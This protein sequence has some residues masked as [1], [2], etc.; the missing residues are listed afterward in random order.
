MPGKCGV[1]ILGNSGV[2]K[3]FLAN[4]LLDQDRFPHKFSPESV[5]TE[6]EQ[7]DTSF[8]GQVF[9]IFNIPGLI[10]AEQDKIDR[11]KREIERAFGQKLNSLILF[12]FGEQ[13][14]RIRDEDIVTFQAIHKAYQFKMDSL[15]LIVNN[16]TTDRQNDYEGETIT[17][18]KQKV[19]I[20]FEH[21]C[22]LD[23]INKK[24]LAERQDLRKKLLDKMVHLKPH[25][26]IKIQ[27]IELQ[28]SMIAELKKDIQELHKDF[29][30]QRQKYRD[31]IR[32]QQDRYKAQLDAQ[33]KHLQDLQDEVTRRKQQ[34]TSSVSVISEDLH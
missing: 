32:H 31:Q 27:D 10:E 9:T 4:V 23:E 17:Y 2:G 26:H 12:V 34:T 19:A 13:G 11:N 6:T 20:H 30:G 22:F 29:E 3:S 16:L 14:G 25:M 1:I 8:G 5:T 24:N 21:I 28:L 7:A 33:T 18:L 15:L